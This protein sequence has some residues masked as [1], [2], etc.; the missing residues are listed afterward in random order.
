[1]TD[2]LRNDSSFARQAAFPYEQLLAYLR[3]EPQ[4]AAVR[5]EVE[6][7]LATNRRWRAHHDSVRHL[8][9]E[10]VA[11]RHDGKALAAFRPPQA[12]PLCAIVA[13]TRGEPLRLL[14]GRNTDPIHGHERGEWERHLPRCV[15]CRRMMRLVQ[16]QVVRD[17]HQVREPLLREWLLEPLYR[18]ELERVTAALAG[19]PVLR[20]GLDDLAEQPWKK[21][22]EIRVMERSALRRPHPTL[23]ELEKRDTPAVLLPFGQGVFAAAAVLSAGVL[24][25]IPSLVSTPASGSRGNGFPALQAL[26]PTATNDAYWI[27]LGRGNPILAEGWGCG[28]EGMPAVNG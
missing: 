27:A 6:G 10:R 2:N 11:A 19:Q 8:D 16:A 22:A 12:T 15:Y 26:V 5:A 21:P 14:L 18:E 1:M 28:Q 4:P 23:E 13:K 17:A 20:L 25:G 7:N 24:A 3:G 9:L